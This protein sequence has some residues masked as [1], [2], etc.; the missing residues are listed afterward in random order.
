[1]GGTA[2]PLL[3]CLSYDPVVDL[4][5]RVAAAPCPTYVDDLAALVEDAAQMLRLSFVLPWASRALGLQI[6]THTCRSLYLPQLTGA[7]QHALLTLPVDVQSHETGVR[8]FGLTP[9]LTKKLLARRLGDSALCAAE[10]H[11]E[12]CQCALKSALVPSASKEWWQALMSHTPFG[13]ECVQ[14]QWPYLGA[15]CTRCFN[16]DRLPRGIGMEIGWF[17]MMRNHPI[18]MPI[19]LGR[20]SWLKHR[21]QVAPRYGHWS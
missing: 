5:S 15:T 1:M 4:A 13:S 18:S 21:V 11:Q 6:A 8:V 17:R 19:P 2:S 14:D 3:W 16:Q 20:R 12:P 10:T 9:E 7:L